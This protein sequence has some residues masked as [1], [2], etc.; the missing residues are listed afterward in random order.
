MTM[1][2]PDIQGE[3]ELCCVCQRVFTGIA[4]EDMLLDTSRAVTLA[5]AMRQQA[6]PMSTESFGSL[7]QTMADGIGI[8]FVTG[9]PSSVQG[10]D[11]ILTFVDRLTKQA[12]FVRMRSTIDPAGTSDLNIQN[13]FR[14]HG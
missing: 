7:K 14:L 5:S 1:L 8:D 11:A 2:L 9:L 12:H 6:T 10:K 3:I 4:W 13:V